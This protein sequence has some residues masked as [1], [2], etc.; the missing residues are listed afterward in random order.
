LILHGTK[1]S[2]VPVEE[3]DRLAAKLEEAGVPYVYDRLDGWPH[4]MDF[5]L[6]VNKRFQ[7]FTDAFFSRYLPLPEQ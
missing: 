2:I 1:D 7:Y 3:S 4:A 6:E 5:A